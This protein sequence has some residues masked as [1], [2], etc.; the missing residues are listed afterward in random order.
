MGRNGD[1]VADEMTRLLFEQAQ[2]KRLESRRLDYDVKKR[3]RAKKPDDNKSETDYLDA[4][5]KFEQAKETTW[6]AMAKLM[7]Y[8]VRS[9]VHFVRGSVG[10]TNVRAKFAHVPAP[11]TLHDCIGIGMLR[12]FLDGW[13]CSPPQPEQCQQLVVLANAQLE[14]YRAAIAALEPVIGEL[15]AKYVIPNKMDRIRLTPTLA[16]HFG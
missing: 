11:T 8:E 13:E 15:K 16:Y 4:E 5:L 1:L 7:E 12:C 3:Q 14:F 2:R 9:A 6:N 10:K